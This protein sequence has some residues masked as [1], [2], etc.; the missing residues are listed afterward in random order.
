VDL[1]ARVG[2][3]GEWRSEKKRLRLRDGKRLPPRI[4]TLVV[5][6]V[7]TATLRFDGMHALDR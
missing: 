4:A 6:E 7:R 2:R 3:G 5:I 1:I